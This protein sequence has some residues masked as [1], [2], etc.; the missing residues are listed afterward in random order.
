[1]KKV[2]WVFVAAL[3]VFQV[4]FVSSCSNNSSGGDIMKTYNN[5]GF[6]GIKISGPFVVEITPSDTFAIQ[7][8][9]PENWFD[10]ISVKQTGEMLEVSLNTHWAFW[11][12]WNRTTPK[13]AVAMPQIA[14]LD[15]SGACKGTAKGFHSNQ[16]FKAQVSGASSAGLD[17]QANF[18]SVNVSGASRIDGQLVVKDAVVNISGASSATFDGSV[19]TINLQ[20]SGASKAAFDAFKVND[21]RIELSGASRATAALGGKL[22]AFLSGAS[23]LVYSGNPTLGQMDV[24]GASTLKKK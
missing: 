12:W 1:M 18:A 9:A 20:A 4:V 17:V 13:I 14:A 24:T 6:T 7:I 23:S 10:N 8:T 15:L 16:D 5:T 11:N 21:A 3:I 2:F 22:D 19:D